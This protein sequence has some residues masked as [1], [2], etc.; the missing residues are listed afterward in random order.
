MLLAQSNIALFRWPLDDPRM[1]GFVSEIDTINQLAES[2]NGFVWRYID[3]YDPTNRPEPFNNPHLFFNMSV[4]QDIDSLKSYVFDS[5]HV[6]IL[7]QKSEWTESAGIQSAVMWWMRESA[8]MPSV[9]DAI[10]RF[11]AL[12]NNDDSIDV[13]TFKDIQT[14]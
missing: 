8:Q 6:Q 13:F 11:H 3:D 9:E 7:R 4:W 14:C 2:S 10:M 12:N 5:K 1:A